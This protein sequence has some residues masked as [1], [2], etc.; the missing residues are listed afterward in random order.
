MRKHARTHTLSSQNCFWWHLNNSPA[1]A[2]SHA[3]TQTDIIK[4]V[5][6]GVLT[7]PDPSTVSSRRICASFSPLAAPYTAAVP[8]RCDRGSTRAP[9][10]SNQIHLSSP[11]SQGSAVLLETS[12]QLHSAWTWKGPC[13]LTGGNRERKPIYSTAS[14]SAHTW[15]CH[16][17]QQRNTDALTGFVLTRCCCV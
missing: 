11:S 13:T 3:S 1:L 7:L 6:V 15:C 17:N 12:F 4:T 10:P 8:L 16:G 9:L 14:N 2:V 5:C